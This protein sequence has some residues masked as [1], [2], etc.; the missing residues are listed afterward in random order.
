MTKLSAGLSSAKHLSC[1]AHCA[2]SWDGMLP[3]RLG[4][5]LSLCLMQAEAAMRKPEAVSSQAADL[6]P[7]S[8]G[9]RALRPLSSRPSGSS[10]GFTEAMALA[11][12]ACRSTGGLREHACPAGLLRL[13]EGTGVKA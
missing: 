2:I 13:V 5:Q 4:P 1:A 12:C 10:L 3:A 11:R 6:K 8:P 9:L 7:S